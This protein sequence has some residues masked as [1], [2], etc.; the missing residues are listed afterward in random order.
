MIAG[1][2]G[3][4]VDAVMITAFVAVM[5]IAVEYLNVLT[6]GAFERALRAAPALQYAAAVLLGATP[7]CLG[8][9]TVVALYSHRVVTIGAVVGA[10]IATFGDEAF[11]M[12]A[13]VPRTAL[14]LMLGLAA[15]GFATAPLVDVLAGPRRYAPD[16]CP[17]LLVHAE[18]CRC[19]PRRALLTHWIHPH[20]HRLLLLV[21]MAGFASWVAAGGPGVPAP[22]SWVRFTLMTVSVFGAFVVATVP[23][24]FLDEH[25]W[26]HVV[27]HHVPRVFAWTG[28]VLVGLAV[29]EE[30][31]G[32]G[33]ITQAGPWALL[34]V[35]TLIGLIP[36]SGPHLVFVTLYAAGN[37]PLSVLAASSIVQDGHGMLPLLAQSRADFLRV[38]LVNFSVG[39]AVGSALLLV[40]L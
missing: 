28:A 18:E 25:L 11:V 5:M 20:R 10:M 29:I 36:E 4:L 19:W 22:W 13:L 40:G 24:H 15:L 27:L 3:A 30:V 1:V 12:L 26:G 6:R 2:A 23:D 17:R 16:S 31:A 8:A 37:L 21:G 39:L 14:W 32:P 38:K 9:F 33:A 34:I 35:A 7:G